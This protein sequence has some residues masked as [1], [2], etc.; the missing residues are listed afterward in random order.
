[1]IGL[2]AILDG[3]TPFTWVV[4]G[5]ILVLLPVLV[6]Y[7][8]W[9]FLRFK[10]HEPVALRIAHPRAPLTVLVGNESINPRTQENPFLVDDNGQYSDMMQMKYLDG[11][12][13]Y[14]NNIPYLQSL[15]E[16]GAIYFQECHY[17]HGANG[18]GRGIFSF[19]LRP[20][21]TNFQDPGTIH[22]LS[23]GYN[24]WRVAK[25]GAALPQESFPWEST[26]PPMEHILSV[27]QIW[28][29]I[30]FE[31]WFTGFYARTWDDYYPYCS[32]PKNDN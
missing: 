16:G 25:G 17:C 22:N 24:F 13:A 8:T 18:N 23:V 1:M 21:A 6:W 12:P 31:C 30:L 27:E 9:D 26:M 20:T 15:R 29:V 10:I 7:G 4:R 32:T 2:S 19:S 11:N 14:P 28:K 3:K 5:I